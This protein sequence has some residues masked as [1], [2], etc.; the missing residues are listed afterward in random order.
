MVLLINISFLIDLFQLFFNNDLKAIEAFQGMP[1]QR[2]DDP[3]V[4]QCP[5]SI[6]ISDFQF[7]EITDKEQKFLRMVHAERYSFRLRFPPPMLKTQ[8]MGRH[9]HKNEVPTGLLYRFIEQQSSQSV[10]QI[11]FPFP[12]G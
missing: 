6:V 12:G 11:M 1:V 9:V 10:S 8:L 3:P 4:F 5:T 7:C 2:H